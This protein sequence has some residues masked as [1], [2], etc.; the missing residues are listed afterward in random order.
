M[1]EQSEDGPEWLAQALDAIRAAGPDGLKPGTLADLVGRSRQTIRETLR[2]LLE[3]G[4]L[5]YR[6]NGP[7]SVYI[8]PD[9][10]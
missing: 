2:P 1:R 10:T 6:D 9:H 4:E 3:R 8:H 7:H 5:L